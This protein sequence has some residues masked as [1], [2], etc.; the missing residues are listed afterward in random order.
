VELKSHTQTNT[1]AMARAL[2]IYQQLAALIPSEG[3]G[4][5]GIAPNILDASA[6]Q[7]GS[8]VFGFQWS[9]ETAGEKLF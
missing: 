4:G 6:M 8:C 5:N 2:E 1:P 9:G 7:S 3:A